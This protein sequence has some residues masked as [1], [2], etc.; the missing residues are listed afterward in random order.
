[1]LPEKQQWR[2]HGMQWTNDFV[3]GRMQK[4]S[5]IRIYN[6]SGKPTYRYSTTGSSPTCG[7]G[8]DGT[9]CTWEHGGNMN[10]H[11]AMRREEKIILLDILLRRCI[12][13]EIGTI[14]LS[15]V[16]IKPKTALDPSRCCWLWLSIDSTWY[17]PMPLYHA[18]RCS[19]ERTFALGWIWIGARSEACSFSS[20][21]CLARKSKDR[22]RIF[23]LPRVNFEGQ[24]STTDEDS[25]QHSPLLLLWSSSPL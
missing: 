7:G 15:I 5:S 3:W 2:Q 21:F 12:K 23:W 9:T 20:A 19:I 14:W 13:N 8:R 16:K 6:H 4:S 25:Q 22:F 1:M 24:H 17:Q 10:Y 11:S 18:D